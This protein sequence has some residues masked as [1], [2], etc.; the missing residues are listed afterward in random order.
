MEIKSAV[1]DQ[2]LGKI[3]IPAFEQLKNTQAAN[4]LNGINRVRLDYPNDFR[5]FQPAPSSPRMR[6]LISLEPRRP[7]K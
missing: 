6:I 3:Y 4:K 2:F 1:V 5:E 7:L